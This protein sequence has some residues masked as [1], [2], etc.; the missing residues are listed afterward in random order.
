M[1]WGIP[2][3]TQV[4]CITWFTINIG[5][6]VAIALLGL[7]YSTDNGINPHFRPGNT[8]VLD[9]SSKST[10][11]DL[12]YFAN[13]LSYTQTSML[14]STS[15]RP[16]FQ[17]L[18]G[19]YENGRDCNST[20]CLVPSW[21]Y[22]FTDIPPDTNVPAPVGSYA[23]T[24]K[25]MVSTTAKCINY[26]I[27][28]V[29]RDSVV[30]IDDQ[31]STQTERIDNVGQFYQNQ[32]ATFIYA[33]VPQNESCGSGCAVIFVLTP[34]PDIIY[35]TETVYPPSFFKCSSTSSFSGNTDTGYSSVEQL[36]EDSAKLL[37]AA[38]A[39]NRSSTNNPPSWPGPYTYAK[40]SGSR[41]S[42]FASYDAMNPWYPFNPDIWDIKDDQDL[43]VRMVESTISAFSAT[44]LAAADSLIPWARNEGGTTPSNPTMLNIAEINVGAKIP[45]RHW[46][47]GTQL[48]IPP[49][50]TVLWPYTLAILTCIPLLQFLSLVAV[51]VYAN[52]AIV[53]DDSNLSTAKLLSPIIERLGDHGCLLTG[54]EIVDVLSGDKAKLRYDAENRGLVRHVGVF[55]EK[56]RTAVSGASEFPEGRYNGS[57][58]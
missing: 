8:S 44:A 18:E 14:I 37:S 43:L 31:N 3:L 47:H 25:R 50:L 22:N 17:G 12:Y 7:A 1:R 49:K 4:I 34:S 46:I 40:T 24:S 52:K 16:W 11:Q 26:T 28:D 33:D 10:M 5:G 9:L 36:P 55:E 51:V 39:L 19:V 42:L 30:Y 13:T 20:G 45:Q 58:T 57:E 41:T 53:K 29:N 27:S 23:T 21:R 32:S 48:Y 56:Y 15:I 38:I 2:N 35:K 54:E 6:A